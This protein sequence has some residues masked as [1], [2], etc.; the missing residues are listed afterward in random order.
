M[1]H[2]GG[3]GDGEGL[4]K[5]RDGEGSCA[6]FFEDGAAGGITE[7]VKDAVDVG[8]TAVRFTAIGFTAAHAG[9]NGRDWQRARRLNFRA[10]CASRLR[11]FGGRRRPR[12]TLLDG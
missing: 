6:E 5:A 8:Y 10:V 12:R 4:G 7:G 1:L 2:D 11:A 3:E 9:T